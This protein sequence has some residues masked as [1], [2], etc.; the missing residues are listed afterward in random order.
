MVVD[1][2][3]SGR[4]HTQLLVAMT[5]F[6]AFVVLALA[7]DGLV[8]LPGHVVLTPSVGLAVPLGA[9]FGL[10]AAVGLAVATAVV[11]GT[12]TG[13]SMLAAFD[14]LSLFVLALVA[15]LGWRSELQLSAGTALDASG[16]SGLVALTAV[17]SVG[18]ASVLAWGGEFLGLFPFYVTFLDALVRSLVAT[19]VVV[20]VLVGANSLLGRPVDGHSAESS[21]RIHRGFVWIPFLW[22]LLAVIGSVG[23][24]IRERIA[25]TAFETYGVEFLYHLVHPDL[26][27]R[28]GRR[29]QVAFGAVMLVAWAVTFGRTRLSNP[30]EASTEAVRED[31]S[32]RSSLDSERTTVSS[33]PEEAEVR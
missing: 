5:S 29:A 20:S 4:V 28:S 25:E 24:N 2:G 7:L 22:A 9:A 1:D 21:H 26:F 16:V 33:R 10:P 18:G 27:G 3:H 8:V 14:G 17:G 30:Q 11:T 13:L 15:A 23:F 12:Q 19:A 32:I 31:E 6:V